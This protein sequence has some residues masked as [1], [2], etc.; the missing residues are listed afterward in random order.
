MPNDLKEATTGAMLSEAM[1]V[2]V[3]ALVGRGNLK[4]KRKQ[5]ARRS[6]IG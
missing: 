3:V 2:A 1:M 4:E 6:E 5:V